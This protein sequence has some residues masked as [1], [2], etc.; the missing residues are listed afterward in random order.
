MCFE[1]MN[2]VH[3]NIQTHGGQLMAVDAALA[4]LLPVT[5]LTD[6]ATTS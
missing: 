1:E 2:L 6:I 3:P 4:I 5:V